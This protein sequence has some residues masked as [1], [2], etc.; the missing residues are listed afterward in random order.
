MSNLSVIW[1]KETKQ[2]W[3]KISEIESQVG[4]NYKG[5][6]NV[7]SSKRKIKWLII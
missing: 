5:S 2:A 6:T 4:R 3:G 1:V 7:D